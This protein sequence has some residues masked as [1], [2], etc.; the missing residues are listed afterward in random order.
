MPRTCS[1]CDHNDLSEIN[2]ALASNEPLR[3]IADRW[4]VSKTALIRHRNQHLPVSQLKAKEAEEGA[5]TDD[6]FE[7]VRDLQERALATLDRAEQTEELSA[8]LEAIRE[9][10]SNLELLARLLDELDERSQTNA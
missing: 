10:K 2:A 8:A 3:T 5:R 6:L 7:Q 4:S 9:A 1:V